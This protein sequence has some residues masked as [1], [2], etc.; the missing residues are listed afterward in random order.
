MKLEYNLIKSK[1]YKTSKWSGGTTTELCIYPQSSLY[2]DRNFS[3]RISSATVE[4]EKSKFT[5]LSDYDR[6]I[7]VLKGKL[8]LKHD[9]KE[10]I[11]LNELDQYKFDGNANTESEGKVTDFNLMMRKG[12]CVGNVEVIQLEPKSTLTTI[13]EEEKVQEYSQCVDIYYNIYGE[14]KIS[15]NESKA[16]ILENKDTLLVNKNNEKQSTLFECYNSCDTESVLIKIRIF[17]NKL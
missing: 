9:F 14:I 8:V 16:I 10:S 3:W 7:M 15:I 13:L 12:S 6:I 17:F 11:T 2:E 1:Q 5:M 4:S